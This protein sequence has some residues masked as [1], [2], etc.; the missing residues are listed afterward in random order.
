MYHLVGKGYKFFVFYLVVDTIRISNQVYFGKSGGC[1]IVQSCFGITVDQRGHSAQ[2]LQRVFSLAPLDH[3]AKDCLGL[4][5]YDSDSEAKDYL[6][7][8]KYDVDSAVQDCLCLTKYDVD[9]AEDCLCLTEHDVD[10]AED[11][12]C[13]TEHD[14]DSVKD[15]LCLTKYQSDSVEDYHCKLC[16][17]WRSRIVEHREQS[18]SNAYRDREHGCTW[19]SVFG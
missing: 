2:C 19:N 12:L 10:S 14:V 1:K 13:L 4:M 17:G 16:G 7:L 15:Y 5:E 6:R 8:T 9:S 11:C 18:G 3:Q